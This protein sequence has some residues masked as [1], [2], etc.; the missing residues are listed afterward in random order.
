MQASISQLLH[1]LDLPS[2]A[3]VDGQGNTY[4]GSDLQ[5]L[6]VCRDTRDV[7]S[8]ALFACIKGERLDGHD[9]AAQAVEKGAVAL[10]VQRPLATVQVPQIIVSAATGVEDA[11]VEALGVLA[12][13][14]RKN[15][16]QTGGKVV[17]VTG[18]A[19]K[20]T[21][22][23]VLA[24]VLQS[25]GKKVA[26]NQMNYNNLIGM[27]LSVLA[28]TGQEDVWVME[29]GINLPHEMDL[30]GSILAPDVAIVL[31]VGVAHTEGL[32]E[33]G[34]AWHK[35]RLLAHVA[36]DGAAFVCAD[37]PDLQTHAQENFPAVQ[38]FSATSFAGAV[39]PAVT[40]AYV[41]RVSADNESGKYNVRLSF[42]G[43]G[44]GQRFDIEA[45]FYGSYGAEN[46]AAVVAVALH[47]G[48]DVFAI[49]QAFKDV[50]LPK[51]RFQVQNIDGWRIID[52]SYNANPL[53]MQR[54]VQAALEMAEKKPCYAVLGAM[55]ELGQE[56]EH[57]HR[58]LGKFLAQTGI[59]HIF[60]KGPHAD[61]VQKGLKAKK[62][63]GTFYP[64]QHVADFIQQWQEASL[65]AG[66]VLFKGSRSNALETLVTAL[67]AFIQ[68]N[69]IALDG[70]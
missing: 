30:L 33:K 8:G 44:G 34:V 7:T 9:F 28:S 21:V 29:A 69:T 62:F 31:N 65:P 20:T 1:M 49:Q 23:E 4:Q 46:V 41:G 48:M 47:L 32:G 17:A 26:R 67:Q 18:S 50:T 64:I 56:A 42:G 66:T 12:H 14:W 52:D 59:Q 10:L 68:K 45:P 36:Q 35:A 5:V 19:G 40:A 70:K 22:K 25:S 6:S 54:M 63:T 37:Y 58:Q 61:M 55:G 39:C 51:Q 60:W 43:G 27:P 11:T 57:E 2:T 15:F 16:A 3:C 53:S 38:F 24:H 13:A